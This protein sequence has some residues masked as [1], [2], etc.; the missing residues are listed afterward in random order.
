MK[1]ISRMLS[2]SAISVTE[3]RC[4][5]RKGKLDRRLL[6]DLSDELARSKVTRAEIWINGDGRIRFS[7]EI[8]RELH[9]RLRNILTQV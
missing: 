6:L 2:V 1:W 5:L 9:Q 8:P 4:E 7:D 3:G